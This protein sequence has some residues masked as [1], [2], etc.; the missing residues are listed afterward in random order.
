MNLFQW[1]LAIN[2]IDYVRQSI[3]PFVAELGMD[4]IVAALADF[5]SPAA[6]EHCQETL[7]QIIDNSID[8]VR[9]K[10]IDLLFNVAN[11]ASELLTSF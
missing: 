5:Q 6:A 3:Q 1:C 10:I 7:N 2:N 9:N 4:S 8:T 11:K